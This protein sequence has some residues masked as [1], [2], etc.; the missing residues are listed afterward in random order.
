MTTT[1]EKRRKETSRKER[2]ANKRLRRDERRL[3]KN[4]PSAEA[5][6]L[7]NDS[8]EPDAAADGVADAPLPA[9][10]G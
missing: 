2:Q 6:A 10:L 4:L 9:E 5:A 7:S 3:R 1:F 8:N